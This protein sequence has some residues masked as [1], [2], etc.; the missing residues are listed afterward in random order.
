MMMH[1]GSCGEPSEVIARRMVEHPA[2][3]YRSSEPLI[4]WPR[5]VRHR[6]TLHRL[7]VTT[8]KL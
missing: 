8:R 5:S 7:F 4:G 6:A 3:S 1:K 2:V